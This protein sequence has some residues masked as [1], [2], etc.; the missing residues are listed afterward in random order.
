MSSVCTPTARAIDRP[1]SSALRYA[2]SAGP[3]SGR[4]S[5][6][7]GSRRVERR[8]VG[9][10][11]AVRHDEQVGRALVELLVA[12]TCSVFAAGSHT[13][14]LIPTTWSPGPTRKML[15]LVPS[16]GR[17]GPRRDRDPRLDVEPVERVSTSMSHNPTGESRSS[18]SP[19]RRGGRLSASRRRSLE[20]A[21]EGAGP[22][23]QASAAVGRTSARTASSAARRRIAR[24]PLS[25]TGRADATPLRDA[26]QRGVGRPPVSL[27]VSQHLLREA[28]NTSS[29]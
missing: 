9:V 17:W 6:R 1:S 25:K 29:G 16:R 26:R 22:R 13:A 18:A 3:S 11:D 10:V 14:W 21:R 15:S 8:A 12:P 7:A 28:A 27:P 4:S 23:R 2:F 20:V 19:G 5:G 24:E